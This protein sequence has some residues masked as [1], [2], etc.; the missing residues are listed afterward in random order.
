[1]KRRNLALVMI[2]SF[3]LLV[4]L[5]VLLQSAARAGGN[6]YYVDD[7]C[8]GSGN[9]SLGDPWCT[10]QEAADAVGAGDTV[11]INPGTYAGGLQVDVS[12]T[13]VNPITFKGNGANVIIDGDG[14]GQDGMNIENADYIIIDGIT[15][16]HASRAGVRRPSRAGGGRRGCGGWGSSG[17]P[18]SARSRR[19]RPRQARTRCAPGPPSACPAAPCGRR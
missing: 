16:Q 6:T 17:S 15:V 13:A 18:C 2:L 5:F 9:G 11:L 10:I 1:M 8:D 14:S 4:G 19:P 7:D 3:I 12:G